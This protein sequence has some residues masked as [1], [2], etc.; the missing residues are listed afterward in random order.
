MKIFLIL[1]NVVRS[2]KHGAHHVGIR[3]GGQDADLFGDML[4]LKG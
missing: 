1:L 2:N 4:K 3:R